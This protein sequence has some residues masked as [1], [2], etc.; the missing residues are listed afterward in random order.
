[1]HAPKAG[2]IDGTADVM[3]HGHC[4]KTH[5]STRRYNTIHN[6]TKHAQVYTKKAEAVKLSSFWTTPKRAHKNMDNNA[7]AFCLATN[8]TDPKKT[9]LQR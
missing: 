6:T 2:Q 8:A 9:F 5:Q 1:M 3:S 7:V 4:V